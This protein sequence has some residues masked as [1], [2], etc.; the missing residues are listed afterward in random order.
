[1]GVSLLLFEHFHS[2]ENCSLQYSHGQ[3]VW[4]YV[5]LSLSLNCHKKRWLL[6]HAII[7]SEFLERQICTFMTNLMSKYEVVL[8]KWSIS[9]WQVGLL[10]AAL[11]VNNHISYNSWLCMEVMEPH[12]SP[13]PDTSWAA[14]DTHE[15]RAV[16]SNMQATWRPTVRHN[17]GEIETTFTSLTV[18]Y[19]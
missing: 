3:D 15:S 2:H 1:M 18:A 6:M 16:S 4:T 8:G 11:P 13:I 17:T 5:N 9:G 10:M 14:I 7:K 12:C 19:W